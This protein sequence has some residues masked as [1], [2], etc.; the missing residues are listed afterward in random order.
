MC[1]LFT[2]AIFLPISFFIVSLPT[3]IIG[4]IRPYY[5]T[6]P[7][8]ISIPVYPSS[9]NPY[10]YV[11]GVQKSE[12]DSFGENSNITFFTGS[13][14]RDVKEKIDLYLLHNLW[15]YDFTLQIYNSAGSNVFSKSFS[16]NMNITNPNDGSVADDMDF[17]HNLPSEL[18]INSNSRI[19][20]PFE[21]QITDEIGIADSCN[22]TAYTEY[23]PKI[24]KLSLISYDFDDN[25][26]NLTF[27]FKQFKGYPFNYIGTPQVYIT[28]FT[29]TNA[30]ALLITGPVFL[31]IAVLS[32]V[33]MLTHYSIVG[34]EIF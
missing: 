29:Q 21:T 27:V 6:L 7:A 33:L 13:L 19:Y 34:Y 20:C 3:W 17:L 11:Y 1:V 31:V 30:K 22:D 25:D 24:T 16:S 28:G 14:F 8:F 15:G 9:T 4:S 23:N 12:A 18:F 32:F 10:G 2:F 5:Y 26:R